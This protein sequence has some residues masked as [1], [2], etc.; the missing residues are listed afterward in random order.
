ML[1]F[2]KN[3]WYVY[4]LYNRKSDWFYIGLH[5]QVGNKSYSHSS[6]SVAL[7]K[8][9]EDGNV[10]EYIVFKGEEKEK[11]HALETYLINLAKENGV[12]V[13]NNNSG[14]GHRGGA[15][16]NIL[17][18]EDYSVAENMILHR[19]FPTKNYSTEEFKVLNNKFLKL[20]KEVGEAVVAHKDGKNIIHEVFYEPIDVILD[21]PFLQI[22]E[23]AVDKKEVDRVV[24]SMMRDIIKAERLVEP[25]TV[26]NFPNGNKL[27]IDGTTTTYA[28]KYCNIWAEVP[29]VYLNSD[30][31][32]NSQFLM[33]LYASARN[34]PEKYKKTLDPSK[35][36]KKRIRSFHEANETMFEDNWEQFVE[37]FKALYSGTFSPNQIGSN[38]SAY[39]NSYYE[40]EMKGDNWINYKIGKGKILD[41]ISRRVSNK[42]P[43]SVCTKVSFSNLE[44]EAIANPGVFFGNGPGGKDTEVVL[45]HHTTPETEGHEEEKFERT[46]RAFAFYNFYPD[47]K[48]ELHGYTPF[49]GKHNGVKIYI[50]TL[51]SR[52]DTKKKGDIAT[53]IYN[54]LFSEA[55]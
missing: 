28:I 48:K 31:F 1:N 14:G 12:S 5:H 38:L 30:I 27:R 13:Y 3:Y 42:F 43:K 46:A 17:E 6:S 53:N 55:G 26:V 8:A 20:A 16:Q 19:I 52:I 25:V 40:E 10:D 54:S 23:N 21:L 18:E 33:E 36:L 29:V 7:K 49:V 9:I 4:V 37:S 15:R 51:P 24:E 47:K 32:E 45:A 35:E 2:E 34:T 41:S 22:T 11:A 39:R 50:V 44:R